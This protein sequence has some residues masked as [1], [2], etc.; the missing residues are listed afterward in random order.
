VL[1]QEDLEV[2]VEMPVRLQEYVEQ[3]EILLLKLHHKETRAVMLIEHLLVQLL[4][5][6]WQVA[7]A[8][9]NVLVGTESE[10][11]P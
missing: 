8:V 4:Q 5:L 3:Q 6:I 1:I 11:V 10:L 7:V 9:L 2:E